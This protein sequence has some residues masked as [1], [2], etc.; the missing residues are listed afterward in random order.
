MS[1]NNFSLTFNCSISFTGNVDFRKE[2]RQ[3]SYEESTAQS[4]QSDTNVCIY[5]HL[6][7]LQQDLG[8]F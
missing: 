2:K 8:K 7:L 4:P 5:A 3:D 6:K 1:T